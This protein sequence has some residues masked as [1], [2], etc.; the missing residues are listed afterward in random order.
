MKDRFRFLLLLVVSL[1]PLLLNVLY[2][3]GSNDW[4]WLFPEPGFEMY[5][6][7]AVGVPVPVM[8]FEPLWVLFVFVSGVADWIVPLPRSGWVKKGET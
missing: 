3:L 1:L 5:K 6:G 7:V 8:L 2:C 4:V